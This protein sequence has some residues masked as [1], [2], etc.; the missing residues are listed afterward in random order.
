M[1]NES[2]EIVFEVETSSIV[3]PDFVDVTPDSE[4]SLDVY[5]AEGPAGPQGPLGPIGLTGPLGPIGPMG[6][7]GPIGA[8]GTSVTAEGIT[9]THAIPETVWEFVNPFPYRPDVSTYDNDGFELFGDL[10]FPPGLIRVEFYFPT[11]GTIRLR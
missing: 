11:T 7:I 2:L 8:T 10:S 5:M 9:Y 4:T 1:S 6:L 3:E